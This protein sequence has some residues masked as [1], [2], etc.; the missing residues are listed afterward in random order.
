MKNKLIA[1][2]AAIPFAVAGVFNA[3]VTNAVPIIQFDDQS[4][5]GGL[6]KYDG[7]GGSLIG[8][9]FKL[10]I[11]LGIDTPDNNRIE[12]NCE[13]CVLNFETGANISESPYIFALGGS[14]T[15]EGTVKDDL[16][17]T[18]ASGTLVSGSFT[19]DIIGFACDDSRH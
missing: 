5:D 16:N 13:D 15:I 18:I 6:I 1:T 7:E 14:V 19:E 4:V 11:I 2:L 17:N 3:S 9:N 10:D 8:E 12:L